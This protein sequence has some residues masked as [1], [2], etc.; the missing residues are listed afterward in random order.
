MH[1]CMHAEQ[2]GVNLHAY[3][4]VATRIDNTVMGIDNAVL[5]INDS[6]VMEIIDS[7][8]MEIDARTI[9]SP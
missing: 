2:P 4:H 7:T 8:V 6:T 3:K 5:G 9:E 1:A